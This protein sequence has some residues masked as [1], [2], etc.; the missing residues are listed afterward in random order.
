MESEE[1]VC[2]G[3][4]PAFHFH[5]AL[6]GMLGTTLIGDQV[7]QVRE[8]CQK[9]LLAAIWVVE[10]F[11]CKQLPLNRVMGLIQEGTGDGHLRVCED[12]IPARLLVLQPASHALAV[13]RPRRVGD[14][15]GTVA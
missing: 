2:G 12:R 13:G 15:V 11:H 6:T 14:V 4:S 8:P 1:P 5:P 9:C 10:P 7:V 3:D